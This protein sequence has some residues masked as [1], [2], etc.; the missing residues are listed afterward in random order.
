MRFKDRTDAGRQLAE[1]LAGRYAD[2]DGIVYALPRG[3]VVLGVEIARR[4]GLPLDLII[5]RKIG[6]PHNPEYA[7]GAVT[8]QGELVMNPR[9]IESVRREWLARE[10]ENERREAE[11]RHAV[12]LGGRTPLS[13]A[14]RTAILVDDGVATGLTMQAAIRAV[15]RQNP[16]RVVVAVPVVP[17]DTAARL[18]RE[19]DEVVAL[20]VATDYF[21]AVGAYYDDFPQVTDSEVI[22]LLRTMERERSA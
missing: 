1:L 13:A 8:E 9:E 15:Q 19:V 17:A 21:G 22:G 18:E 10:I 12:Y 20:D 16:A 14:G 4:L 3:G 11:R 5:A 2:I 6:H 7:I